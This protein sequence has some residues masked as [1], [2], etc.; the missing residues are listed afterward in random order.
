MR[1]KFQCTATPPFS[2]RLPSFPFLPPCPTNCHDI[3]AMHLPWRESEGEKEYK[4]INNGKGSMQGEC[5][6]MMRN[7]N[8]VRGKVKGK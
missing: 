4:G 2:R 3:I 7:V 8:E 6:A 5:R 1:E